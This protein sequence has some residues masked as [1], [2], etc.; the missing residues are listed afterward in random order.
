MWCKHRRKRLADGS[1]IGS[2]ATY[3]HPPYIFMTKEQYEKLRK[4]YSRRRKLTKIKPI[5]EIDSLIYRTINKDWD[6]E[7]INL[8]WFNTD[9]YEYKNR[10][11]IF[12]HRH[13][14]AS[15]VITKNT[16]YNPCLACGGEYR[17]PF[18]E[19]IFKGEIEGKQIIEFGKIEKP[20]SFVRSLNKKY[21]FIDEELLSVLEP[22]KDKITK[23]LK[24]YFEDLDNWFI[25][26][27][28]ENNIIEHK[29]D[30]GIEVKDKICHYISNSIKF[31]I[32]AYNT[33]INGHITNKIKE[34]KNG[35][36]N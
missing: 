35:K 30:M 32:D 13:K 23:M 28:Q 34:N 10:I 5:K 36:L 18:P 8:R 17:V 27:L 14:I 20:P 4:I 9:W 24:D 7:H 25:R 3:M 22:E 12:R 1:F 33:F 6:N 19:I 31:D 15:L 26:F 21:Y 2:I 16:I 29:I 11:F